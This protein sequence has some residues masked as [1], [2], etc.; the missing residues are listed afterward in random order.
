VKTHER[1]LMLYKT[2]RNQPG[3]RRITP[4]EEELLANG[5]NYEHSKGAVHQG[6]LEVLLKLKSYYTQSKNMLIKKTKSTV[7][8]I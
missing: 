3:G 5:R 4:A 2:F 6:K 1:M 7:L 8:F